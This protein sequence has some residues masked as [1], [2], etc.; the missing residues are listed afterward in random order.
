[1]QVHR[2]AI[3]AARKSGV[4]HIIY[5][6]L[7]FGGDCKPESRA[8]VMQAHL[9][10]EAYLAQIAKQDETFTYT[11]IREGIYSE[12]FP[13][14]TAFFDLT[15]PSDIIS[16]PHDGSGPGVAWAKQDDL[17]EA[18]A[19]L[20]ANYATSPKDFPH[21]NKVIL[22]SGPKVWSLAETVEVVSKV[23]GKNISIREVPIEE[24]VR[25]PQIQSA[26]S[27]GS[28]E[29]AAQMATAFE[30]IRVGEAAVASPL[31]RDILGRE[32]EP[33]EETVQNMAKA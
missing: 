20:V 4:K 3:D 33:F 6:S 2:I 18:S 27:Y 10:T 30:A 32:P 23:T 8:F 12:S 15:S 11:A 16:I 5:S 29:A 24:Y 19:R 14:Y 21:I 9:D 22:L 28:G 26:T 13:I 17:G 25:L 1:M 7:A 31:L